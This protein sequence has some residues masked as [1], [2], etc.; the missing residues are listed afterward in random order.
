MRLLLQK[1]ISS[2]PTPSSNPRMQ[3][4]LLSVVTS[5]TPTHTALLSAD[6]SYMQ[7]STIAATT[8]MARSALQNKCRLTHTGSYRNSLPY[9]VNAKPAA[10]CKSKSPNWL[11]QRG[12]VWR[13]LHSL[14]SHIARRS[15]ARTCPLGQFALAQIR[16][17]TYSCVPHLKH[18][19]SAGN[20]VDELVCEAPSTIIRD[21]LTDTIRPILPRLRLMQINVCTRAR[22]D[23]RHKPY[24]IWQEVLFRMRGLRICPSDCQL[25]RPTLGPCL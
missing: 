8:A 16:H 12:H 21:A 25:G 17:L 1:Q 18:V 14:Q 5:K 2:W 9:Q 24:K 22:L 13:A 23:P 3:S 15:R 6:C 7:R 20:N 11:E 10:E 4:S 19:S